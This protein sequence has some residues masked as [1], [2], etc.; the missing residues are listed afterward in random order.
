MLYNLN[1]MD[2]WQADLVK[3]NYYDWMK[4]L[5]AGHSFSNFDSAIS[6][7]TLSHT[8]IWFLSFAAI[9]YLHGKLLKWVRNFLVGKKYKN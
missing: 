3:L 6:H 7:L 1:S 9:V 4:A 2:L 8:T 5:D